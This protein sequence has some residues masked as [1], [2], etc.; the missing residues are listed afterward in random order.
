MSARVLSGPYVGKSKAELKVLLAAAQAR[1]A[2][3]GGQITGASVNGQSFQKTA[4]ASVRTEIRELT[5]AL[6]QVDPDFIAPTSTIRV[7]FTPSGW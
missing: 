5:A 1:L 7:R 2:G 4:G 3:G 6:A